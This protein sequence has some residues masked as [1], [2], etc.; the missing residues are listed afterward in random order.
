MSGVGFVWSSSL[1]LC[2]RNKWNHTSA[3][4]SLQRTWYT[5]PCKRSLLIQSCVSDGTLPSSS[6]SPKV[7]EHD[8]KANAPKQLY[9]P[10]DYPLHTEAYLSSEPIREAL[11]KHTYERTQREEEADRN[12]QLLAEQVTLWRKQVE[13]ALRE[14]GVDPEKVFQEAD[15][16]FTPLE[17]AKKDAIQASIERG[18]PP[19]DIDLGDYPYIDVPDIPENLE[20]ENLGWVGLKDLGAS[21]LPEMIEEMKSRR[22]GVVAKNS[23]RETASEEEDE[24]DFSST[25]S[26]P[27]F[28]Q[29]NKVYVKEGLGWRIGYEPFS[30]GEQCATVGSKDYLI[31]MNK[32]EFFHFRRLLMSLDHKL[33]DMTY[34]SSSSEQQ[35]EVSSFRMMETTT[36]YPQNSNNGME[37]H[38]PFMQPTPLM[39]LE[40]DILRIQAFGRPNWFSLHVFLKRKRP[41]EC[42]WDAE[43]TQGLLK[44]IHEVDHVASLF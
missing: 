10:I 30:T 6:D 38:S 41:V 27:D 21:P 43:A 24:T 18:C 12:L 31:A 35:E 37:D 42:S 44:A 11:W 14:Q 19:D 1:Y 33:T 22:R 25:L 16:I 13:D 39:D 9:R 32:E 15:A 36:T 23:F 29:E 5:F 7:T 34:H 20:L 8:Q 2:T 28:V 17:E 4:H 40:S 3:V 26:V